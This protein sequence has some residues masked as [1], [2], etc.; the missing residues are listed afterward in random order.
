MTGDPGGRTLF[1]FMDESGDLQFGPRAK[2][3][4]ILSAVCTGNPA[5]L[6]AKMQELKYEQMAK[7]STDLEFHATQNSK[8]TRQRVVDTLC[9]MP[10]LRVHSMWVDKAY[11]QPHLQDGAVAKC[12]LQ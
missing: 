8:G 11:A 3:H 2:Q 9:G 6:A 1:V 7:G 12:G 4:F 5:V 10:G